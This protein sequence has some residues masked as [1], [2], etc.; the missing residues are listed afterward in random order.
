MR[1]KQFLVEVRGRL[2]RDIPRDERIA[3]VDIGSTLNPRWHILLILPVLALFWLMHHSTAL[4]L[5]LLIVYF[6]LYAALSLSKARLFVYT[7]RRVMIFTIGGPF[8]RTYKYLREFAGQ[9][10]P[11]EVLRGW[12]KRTDEFG[13]SVWIRKN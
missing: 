6:A 1:R 3:N 9:P 8:G 11:V 5:V 12:W 2:R 4:A 13:E 10:A 7:D